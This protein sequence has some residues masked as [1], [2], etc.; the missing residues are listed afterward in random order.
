MGNRNSA[1]DSTSEEDR[2]DDG[3]VSSRHY[4]TSCNGQQDAQCYGSGDHAHR[5]ALLDLAVADR[6]LAERCAAEQNVAAL[7][8]K[9]ARLLRKKLDSV[10]LKHEKQRAFTQELQDELAR[11]NTSFRA[12]RAEND[13][14]RRRSM[15]VGS[16][17][18]TS[19]HMLH[20]MEAEEAR[21]TEEMGKLAAEHARLSVEIKT[22]EL[23]EDAVGTTRAEIRMREKLKACALRQYQLS[24][25]AA[26]GASMRTA[27]VEHIEGLARSAQVHRKGWRDACEQ[28]SD[29]RRDIEELEARLEEERSAQK[30]LLER[31]VELEGQMRSSGKR[32]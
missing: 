1:E 29:L 8:S 17:A 32:V 12:L 24:N 7:R 23:P 19:S 9:E 16:A 25:A 18:A 15:A 27:T 11:V 2:T 13:S 22:S 14:L 28:C 4:G 20:E 31:S 10:T 26:A 30:L 21:L 3:D 5:R 6:R